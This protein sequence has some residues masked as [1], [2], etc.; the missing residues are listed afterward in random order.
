MNETQ[1]RE[2]Q[3]MQGDQTQ[4]TRKMADMKTTHDQTAEV[5]TTSGVQEGR[6]EYPLE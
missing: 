4:A 3:T 6:K 5:E 2:G 1:V